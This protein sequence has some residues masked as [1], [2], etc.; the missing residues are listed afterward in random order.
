MSTKY[1]KVD[2]SYT[3]TQLRPHPGRK[4]ASRRCLEI[5][6]C[7]RPLPINV[8]M[9]LGQRAPPVGPAASLGD[10]KTMP[11]KKTT[12]FMSNA[13]LLLQELSKRCGGKHQHQQLLDGRAKAAAVYPEGL[14]RAICKGLVR[15]LEIKRGKVKSLLKVSATPL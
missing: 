8:C 7:L 5:R 9:V 4:N 2:G 11:A 1:S 10:R 3:N 15:Q 13:E 14:C 6:E 12:R